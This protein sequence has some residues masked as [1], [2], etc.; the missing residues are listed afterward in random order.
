MADRQGETRERLKEM[1]AEQGAGAFPQQGRAPFAAI[2][3]GTRR[4]A[5]K[6]SAT[7]LSGG[8]A[9]KY[10]AIIQHYVA[11]PEKVDAIRPAH[12]AYLAE[13]K[14]SGKL[15]ASGPF[16]DGTGALIIYKA[17]SA[18]EAQ[19]LLENDPFYKEGVFGPWQIRPWRHVF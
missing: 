10:A 15:F 1:L 16:T 13:L 8:S 9:V 5:A 18:E 19:A 4:C 2:G 6:R 14:A 17:E 12:R 11:T 3:A 7:Y